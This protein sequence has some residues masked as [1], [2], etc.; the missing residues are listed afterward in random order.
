DSVLELLKN[1]DR[2]IP[3]NRDLGG[4]LQEIADMMNTAELAEQV[5][6][7]G[8]ELQGKKLISIPINMQCKGRFELIFLFF[9]LLQNL[10]RQIRIED[11]KLTNSGCYDGLVKMQ[12]KAIV[13]YRGQSG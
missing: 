10:D 9:Q 6:E 8:Q 1:Y 5:G 12:T 4:F 11:V 3:V 2:N 7:P 13:Y